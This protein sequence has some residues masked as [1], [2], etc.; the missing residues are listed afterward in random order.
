[1]S[2]I[3]LFPFIDSSQYRVW[4][5]ALEYDIPQNYEN[6]SMLVQDHPFLESLIVKTIILLPLVINAKG[7]LFVQLCASISTGIT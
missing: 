7:Y 6:H 1:M 2:C 5:L 3:N 4:P